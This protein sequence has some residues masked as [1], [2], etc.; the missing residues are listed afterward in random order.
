M[1][2]TYSPISQQLC[3]TTV[4]AG[5]SWVGW[6]PSGGAAACQE[7]TVCKIEQT[8]ACQ[9]VLG[10]TPAASEFPPKPLPTRSR[11]LTETLT[12]CRGA[13]RPPLGPPQE[14]PR[15]P[16]GLSLPPVLPPRDQGCLQAGH[17][18]WM[19]LAEQPEKVSRG[20]DSPS[21]SVDTAVMLELASS[22]HGCRELGDLCDGAFDSAGFWPSQQEFGQVG[23]GFLKGMPLHVQ[24]I[25][26]SRKTRG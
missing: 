8:E 10:N 12:P 3:G 2:D 15:W 22:A 4:G 24:D 19:G 9:Q 21:P 16:C 11:Q 25:A 26:G 17:L 1:A 7:L 13:A 23:R 6:G 20:A 5:N 18:A 14:G